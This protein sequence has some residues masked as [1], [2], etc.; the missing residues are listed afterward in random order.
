MLKKLLKDSKFWS[1]I[2]LAAAISGAA[3]KPEYAVVAT[4]LATSVIEAAYP[5][6]PEKP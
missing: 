3:V 2:V 1:A 5:I 4:Q 6:E